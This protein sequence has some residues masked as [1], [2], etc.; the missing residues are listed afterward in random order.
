LERTADLSLVD[1]ERGDRL[2]IGDGAAADLIMQKTRRFERVVRS[3]VLDSLEQRTG[4]ITD[5]RN[6]QTDFSHEV[7]PSTRCAASIIQRVGRDGGPKTAFPAC[8]FG[9][10]LTPWRCEYKR[11]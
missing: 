8:T 4:A 10:D 6:R 5:A 3:V 11:T 9:L 1:V 2:D 7:S